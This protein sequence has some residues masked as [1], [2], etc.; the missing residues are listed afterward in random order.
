MKLTLEQ[1]NVAK[2]ESQFIFPIYIQKLKKLGVNNFIT[3]VSDGHTQ[4]FDAENE[5]ISDD[6][7]QNLT[8]SEYIN[9][10]KFI[11]RLQLH[12]NGGTDY[13]TFCKD[14]AE[15]G[16]DNWV[17]NLPAM[18]C[19]YYDKAGNEIFAEEIPDFQS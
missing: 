9:K 8:I 3:F 15:N 1:I 19:I 10:E 11:E 6:P 12:Q 4:Y 5:S 17:V 14:C 7:K 18:T 13:A 2:I 16:I